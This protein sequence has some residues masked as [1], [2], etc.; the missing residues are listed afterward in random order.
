VRI[1]VMDWR[2]PLASR[3]LRGFDRE[4]IHHDAR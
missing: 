1:D 2:A 3:S 4:R